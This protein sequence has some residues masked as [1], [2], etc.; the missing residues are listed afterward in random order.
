MFENKTYKEHL[1]DM[2]CDKECSDEMT[3]YQ[4]QAVDAM[5]ELL[6]V[7][8][9]EELC[10]FAKAKIDGRMIILPC[11]PG[12]NVWVIIRRGT[13]YRVE[14]WTVYKIYERIAGSWFIELKSIR[15]SKIR[16]NEFE[17]IT[18]TISSFGKTVFI[19]RELAEEKLK[20]LIDNGKTL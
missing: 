14:L 11:K 3:G 5:I 7:C 18:R 10:E 2:L 1:E 17:K 12:D 9:Y 16:P 4:H 20:E 8:S 6:S 13:S 15:L 19:S